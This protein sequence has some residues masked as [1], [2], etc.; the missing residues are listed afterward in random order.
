MELINAEISGPVRLKL[1]A[2]GFGPEQH[3]SDTYLPDGGTAFLATLDTVQIDLDARR[4]E[5]KAEC[6]RRIF[7]VVDQE[8]QANLSALNGAALLPADDRTVYLLG[9][10][11]IQEMITMSRTIPAT[12]ND[13]YDDASWPVPGA[14]VIAL[15][16]AY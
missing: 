12:E 15:G 3:G 10:Q 16:E 6:K 2:E 7:D 14:G 4:V 1:A 11:W 8:T 13:I 9:L 5:A